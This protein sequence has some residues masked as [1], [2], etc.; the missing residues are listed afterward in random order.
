MAKTSV[1]Y[2]CEKCGASF[3]RLGDAERCE[4]KHLKISDVTP[5]FDYR[6]GENR[7]PP[8]V[9]IS[10]EGGEKRKYLIGGPYC[11]D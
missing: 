1:M 7:F 4:R 5:E 10:F 2:V 9:I 3:G 8:R 6:E 11:S